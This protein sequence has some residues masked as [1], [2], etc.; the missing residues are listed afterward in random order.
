M[1]KISYF[2]ASLTLILASCGVESNRFKVEGRFLNLN[3]GEF[4]VYSIDNLID[5]IDT[6]KAFCIRYAVR[7]TRNIG[8]GIS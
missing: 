5:G 7:T 6:I 2:I 3:Q 4:Y 8:T 1:N